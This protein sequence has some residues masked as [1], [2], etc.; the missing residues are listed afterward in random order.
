[1]SVM[2]Q[3]K[4]ENSGR[5]RRA[6]TPHLRRIVTEIYLTALEDYEQASFPFGDHMEGLLIWFEFGQATQLN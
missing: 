1:M 3:R 6:A 5:V 4:P 2:N